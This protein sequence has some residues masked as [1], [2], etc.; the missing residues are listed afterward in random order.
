MD[1]IAFQDRKAGVD[2]LQ[3]RCPDPRDATDCAD[4]S[5]GLV[6]NG[7]QKARVFNDKVPY[8]TGPLAGT[9][10]AV[11]RV[12]SYLEL[13]AIPQVTDLEQGPAP[14]HEISDMIASGGD[15]SRRY[16]GIASGCIATAART[17]SEQR[18][19]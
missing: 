3:M 13:R 6:V 12:C 11:Q 17:T 10:T 9:A 7:L 16:R 5:A 15:R 18:K 8:P 19:R 1:F 4:A 2:T 14:L